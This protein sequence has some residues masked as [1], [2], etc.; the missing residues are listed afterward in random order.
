M[1]IVETALNV[2]EGEEELKEEWNRSSRH[3]VES[4]DLQRQKFIISKWYLVRNISSSLPLSFGGA[5]VSSLIQQL[6]K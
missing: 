3:Q 5:M 6:E 1:K 4:V 2:E